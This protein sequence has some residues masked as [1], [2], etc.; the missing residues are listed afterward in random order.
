MLKNFSIKNKLLAVILLSAFFAL[1]VGFTIIIVLNVRAL[2]RDMVDNISLM[3]RMAG[4]YTI[5][6]ISFDDRREAL[7][8]LKKLEGVE[9]VERATIYD[10]HQQM[11]VV[12]NSPRHINENRGQV[13]HTAPA[14][15]D[16]TRI[17][18]IG[19]T[20]ASGR[21]TLYHRIIY[22]NELYGTIC[23]EVTTSLLDIK[24]RNYMVTMLTTGL[25]L[26][27]I[28]ILLALQL[29][30]VI[31]EPLMQLTN[32]VQQISREGD[33]SIRF[34]RRSGDEIG[35]L[36]D[37]FNDMVAQIQDREAQRDKAQEALARALREDF[38]E[39][40][41]NLQNLIYKVSPRSD[42]QYVF[43]LFEGKL[44]ANISTESVLGK[45]LNEVFGSR[46]AEKF[47]SYFDRAF[48]GQPTQFEMMF[49]R[50]YYLNAL[51]PI[52]ENGMVREI[53]GSAVDITGQKASEN[54]LRVNE[55]RYKAL[56]EGLPVGIVQSV[57]RGGEKAVV[58]LEFVNTE[59]VRQTGYSMEM[60]SEM[61]RSDQFSL[62]FHPDDKAEIEARWQ[63]WL[64]TPVYLTLYRTYRLQ[65]R[66]SEYRWFDDYT[67]KFSTES[68]ETIIIQALLDVTEKKIADDQLQVA[69]KKER[70][71]GALKSRFVST[72]SH[73][74]RTPLTG[75]LLSIDLLNRYFDKLTTKQRSDELDKVRNRVN[76][77]TNLMNDFLAQSETQSI[78]ARFRP[79]PLD[80]VELCQNVINDMESV[81]FTGHKGHIE[82]RINT[83]RAIVYGEAKLL[84]HIL[85]NLISN[86]IKYSPTTDDEDL[87]FDHTSTN[88][89]VALDVE[90][91]SEA[92]SVVISVT[93]HGIGIPE[94]EL[95]NLFTQFFR[96]SNASKISGTGVGLSIVKEFV[97]LH[98]GT[99]SVHSHIGIGSTFTVTIPLAHTVQHSSTR[100]PSTSTSATSALAHQNGMSEF[101]TASAA[102]AMAINDDAIFQDKE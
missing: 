64:E 69:L 54:R 11:F 76:E 43:T 52:V 9:E 94:D 21:L 67:T 19:Y 2:E 17:P 55:Q 34:L 91:E 10:K 15:L 60:F 95:P 59:F 33:Y 88:V 90:A 71:L 100:S 45:T 56:V 83:E 87:F 81:S 63:E 32:I 30:R 31:S 92:E 27:L 40:V 25:G 49:R 5:S 84:T 89:V 13:E 51:E 66:P 78:A 18:Q 46:Y 1:G 61:L 29:Q 14:T 53:V 4:E 93:D 41:R 23:L 12:Y 58:R 86:A 74:F 96:A 16:T 102:S 73:E 26:A 37:G 98:G 97:E 36:A 77:L 44:S 85:R 28:S 101:D 82:R 68:G 8:N 75:I 50:K 20:F 79:T 48:Q 70:E 6:A 7:D 42:G 24:T 47:A 57:K 72:V 39:T 62:P 22:N 3:A 99:I 35:I 80:I 38:R 65:I